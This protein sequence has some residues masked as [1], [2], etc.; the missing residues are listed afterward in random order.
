[1]TTR[2]DNRTLN[3]VV[4]LTVV[5]VVAAAVLKELRQPPEER[6][7]HGR[8]LG[9]PY[10]FRPPTPARVRAEFWD[11]DNNA[12]FTPHAFGVGYGVNLA[13]LARPVLPPRD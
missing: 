10:D 4:L 7:W 9:L 13:R 11:P 5:G 2:H 8:I 6:T 1:M 3:R 12:L